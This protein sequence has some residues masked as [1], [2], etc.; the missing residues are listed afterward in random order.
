MQEIDKL[1]ES[2]NNEI[3]TE[4][5]KLQMAVLYETQLN[6]AIKAKEEQ[7]EKEYKD[8]FLTEKEQLINQL[9]SYLEHFVDEFI[10]ENTTQVVESVKV[11]TAEKVLTLFK[12]MVN[13][14]NMQLDSESINVEETLKESKDK[15][16]L[17]ENE[18]I[19]LKK[20]VKLRDKASLI[21]E[22]IHKLNTDM[23][24]GKLLEFAKNLPFDEL[25]TKKLDTYVKT[26]LT[27]KTQTPQKEDIKLEVKEED[28]TNIIVEQTEVDKIL[29]S[30]K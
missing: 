30:F 21:A 19:T 29:A 10:K 6:E 12:E 18:I 23:E 26:V 27:E 9:D 24:K 5:V 1:F 14:F 17:L 15:I 2:I 3:L 22:A 28:S 7:L 11:K 25:F 8:N 20:E 13:N 4:D 16:N